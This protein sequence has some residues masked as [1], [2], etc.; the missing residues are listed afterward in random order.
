[1]VR[2]GGLLEAASLTEAVCF[3]GSPF[4]LPLFLAITLRTPDQLEGL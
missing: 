1:M 4:F 3:G 2:G